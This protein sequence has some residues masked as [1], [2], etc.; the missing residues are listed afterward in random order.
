[1]KP[2]LPWLIAEQH[3]QGFQR[4]TGITVERHC[5]TK[6]PPELGRIEIEVDGGLIRKRERPV[7]ARVLAHLAPAPEDD[8]GPADEI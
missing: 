2:W 1:M 3:D 8:V 4:C 7:V 5:G 6:R